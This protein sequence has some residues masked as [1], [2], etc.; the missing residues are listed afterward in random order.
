MNKSWERIESEG[1]LAF[2]NSP[3]SFFPHIPGNECS[4]DACYGANGMTLRDWFAGQALAALGAV[5][6][7]DS[8]IAKGCYALADAMLARSRAGK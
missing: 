5:D 1:G 4:G 7:E 2:G 6:A 8:S 3:P